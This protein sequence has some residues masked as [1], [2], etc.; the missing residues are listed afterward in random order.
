[1]QSYNPETAVTAPV[2]AIPFSLA[3]TRGIDLSFFSSAYLDVSVQRVGFRLN[4]G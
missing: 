4:A 1:M 2:W 3:A